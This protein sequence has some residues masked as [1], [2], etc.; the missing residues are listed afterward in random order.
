MTASNNERGELLQLTTP[1]LAMPLSALPSACSTPRPVGTP[2]G[3]GAD[4][5]AELLPT[6]KTAAGPAAA[7]DVGV[8]PDDSDS[9]DGEMR[10]PSSSNYNARLF[11]QLETASET[12]ASR[13]R[14]SSSVSGY[15]KRQSD[16]VNSFREA[17]LLIDSTASEMLLPPAERADVTIAPS[18]SGSRG[19][20]LAI[21]GSFVCNIILFVV[22]IVV[23]AQTGS[24]A[25]LSSVI[26]SALDLFSGTVIWAT[27]RFMKTS[28]RYLFPTGKGRFEPVVTIILAAVMA[29]AAIQL[30]SSACQELV[31]NT[32][33][34]IM[35][36]LSMVLLGLTVAIKLA[37]YLFCRS[38][39][40]AGTTSTAAL[41]M[42]H[43]NDVFSN[44]ISMVT[45]GVGASYWA[46][47]DPIGAIMI[48]L[49]IIVNWYREGMEH[50]L[51]LA[52]RAASHEMIQQL[53]WVA[54]NHD[55]RV[56]LVD[57]VRASHIGSNVWVEVDI[58][59]PPEML[60]HE[61]HDIGEALQ[62][63]LEL[64][65]DVDRA[66]VHLDYEIDHGPEDEHKRL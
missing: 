16:V 58:V 34:V 54:M 15:Y 22:K 6:K 9:Y 1:A 11:E 43:F 21:N 24:L 49:I 32:A 37:L 10:M 5:E 57:T 35:T 27:N 38:L 17:D 46:N 2:A 47:A 65:P 52:G 66:H 50:V 59:L 55:S 51:N 29:T 45:A 63:K 42:D 33:E 31:N 19:V 40:E 56:L 30:I 26:D 60:L 4:V 3:A 41:A 20:T 23:L 62:H 12:H 14:T 36:P 39:G 44:G 53:T 18:E 48:G 25:V 8:K 64:I 28:D 61:A 7:Q 13:R